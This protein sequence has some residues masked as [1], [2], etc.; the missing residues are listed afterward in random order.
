MM[1]NMRVGPLTVLTALC[2]IGLTVDAAT[3][4][5][6]TST[7]SDLAATNMVVDFTSTSFDSNVMPG[8]SGI[9]NLV[10]KNTGGR[11]ADN[12]QLW[13]QGTATVRTD[14]RF[15]IG[16]MDPG[17]SK[18]IPII[19][20]VDSKAKTGLTAIQVKIYFDGYKSDGMGDAGQLTTWE[21][22]L[23]IMGNPLFEV[24]PTGTTYY[25]DTIG[26][27]AVEGTSKDSVKD[28]EATL[29]SS[30]ATIIGSSKKYVGDIDSNQTFRIV[31]QIKPSS[32]G[33]C[34]V[35]L[36]LSYSDE[37]STMASDNITLGINVEDAGVDLKVTNVSYAPTGPGE[38]TDI[39]LAL[40]NVG[41]AEA[42]DVTLNLD[43]STPFAPVGSGERYLP[44]IASGEEVT[45][46]FKLAIGWDA[47]TQAYSIP[48]NIAYKVGGTSYSINKSIGVDVTGK[49][50]LEVMGVQ[51][52]SGS[53]RIDVAN[54]G[55]RTADGVKATLII[56]N[57]ASTQNRS[58][59]GR[60]N[61]SQGFGGGA[62]RQFNATEGFGGGDVQRLISYKSDIKSTKQTTF[63]FPTTAT[64]QAILEIEYSGLNN[65]R[66][67][68]TERITLSG[69]SGTDLGSRT[70][71]ASQ[72]SYTYYAVAAA[73]IVVAYLAYRRYKGKK[74]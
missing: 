65:E 12:V 70:S 64:G 63:T 25:K 8:D 62:Q 43:L 69:S 37:S 74:K 48:L 13:L 72:T 45:V 19:F 32:S 66:V 51:T 30:C 2:L 22:P 26:E 56:P 59:M 73:L 40:K 11:K 61:A 57:S 1:K 47:T 16:R 33:A 4:T 54:I 34:I 49:V 52:S 27:F 58:G 14:K 39:M 21:I 31:Y 35:S 10:I 15:Y 44:K 23:T 29:S 17:D 46:D 24:T 53:V 38:Q 55:T 18:T 5:A 60:G 7:S 36:R 9:I 6:A 20:S 41:S 28:V 71:S 68:Q 67:T 42:D 3:S 50:I